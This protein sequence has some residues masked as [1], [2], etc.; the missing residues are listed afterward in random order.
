MEDPA[1]GEFRNLDYVSAIGWTWQGETFDTT[2]AEHFRLRLTS[3]DGQTVV[4]TIPVDK[5]LDA[6]SEPV[7]GMEQLLSSSSS[8]SLGHG[9]CCRHHFLSSSS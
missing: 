3:A 2:A 9:A 6:P 7:G 4:E 1:L 8:S 5:V